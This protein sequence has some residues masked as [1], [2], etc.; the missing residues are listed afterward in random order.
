MRKVERPTLGMSGIWRSSRR[1]I[2]IH[3]FG[4][5]RGLG[6]AVLNEVMLN[7]VVAAPPCDP[8]AA[9][10]IAARVQDTTDPPWVTR[11][12]IP[13]ITLDVTDPPI[14]RGTTMAPS[15]LPGA[16]PGCSRWSE[17]GTMTRRSR[18]S[19]GPQ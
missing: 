2:Q 13:E 4:E 19:T 7:Q 11:S 18:P 3:L 5:E 16:S 9:G 15:R 17:T 10:R 1:Q 6:Y 12:S 8:N 14:G